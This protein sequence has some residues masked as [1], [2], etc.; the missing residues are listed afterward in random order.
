MKQIA[1][2]LSILFPSLLFYGCGLDNYDEPQSVLYGKVTYNG[3]SIGVRGTA[4]KVQMQ[5]Y[6]D[7][8]ELKTSIPVCVTQDGSFQAVLFDGVYKLI[9]RD[10]NGPWVNK[11][12]TVIITVKGSTACEYPVTPYYLI[13]NESFTVSGNNLKATC[14]LEQITA[15]RTITS[16]FLI[17]NKTAFVDDVSSVSRVSISNPKDVSNILIEMN[18]SARTESVLYAL[19]G[20]QMSGVSDILFSKIEKIR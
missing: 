4:E 11:R 10:N 6:Q 14:N 9:H 8:Y 2:I 17:I 3:E 1:F 7:G 5:L 13:R 15:G 12:D 18:L 20:V 16:V 19:I